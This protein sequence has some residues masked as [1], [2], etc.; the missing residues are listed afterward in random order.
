MIFIKGDDVE[1][2]NAKMPEL[3]QGKKYKC[4]NYTRCTD[5]VLIINDNGKKQYYGS[6]NFKK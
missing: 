5:T 2:I 3:T 6:T 4:I 1:C